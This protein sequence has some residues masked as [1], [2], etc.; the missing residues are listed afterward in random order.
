MLTWDEVRATADV[1]TY[2]GHT[3]THPIMSRLTPEE[4]DR[5]IR[6]CRDRLVAE[7]G[8]APRYFAYPNGG[9]DD[10]D[11]ATAEALRRHGFSVAFSTIEGV[12]GADTDWM[13]VRRIP[14]V[15]APAADLAWYLATRSRA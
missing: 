6:E 3:H 8:R 2:G 12:A 7:T 15:N 11:A 4:C 9:R 14:G 5:E 10:F 1:T 13:A